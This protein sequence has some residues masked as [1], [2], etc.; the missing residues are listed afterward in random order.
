MRTLIDPERPA[1]G[2]TGL[3]G[4]G[5]LVDAGARRAAEVKPPGTMTFAF[6]TRAY[7]LYWTTPDGKVAWGANLPSK[8]YLTL[9]EARAVPKEHWLRT[10]RETYAGDTPGE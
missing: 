10:L 5:A 3:L 6:G 7:Y 2:Y 9:T 4:F 1:A 8:D